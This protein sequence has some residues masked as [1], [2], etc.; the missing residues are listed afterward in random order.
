MDRCKLLVITKFVARFDSPSRYTV[1]Q[2]SH[3]ADVHDH[4]NCGRVWKGLVVSAVYNC[5]KLRQYMGFSDVSEFEHIYGRIFTTPSY[6]YDILF[7][8]TRMMD[9]NA[10]IV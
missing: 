1:P 10:L 4:Y 9:F 3:A 6:V 8:R 7:T 2:Q 5:R